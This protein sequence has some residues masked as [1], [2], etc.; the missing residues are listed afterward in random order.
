MTVNDI[1]PKLNNIYFFKYRQEEN[2][3]KK[4]NLLKTQYSYRFMYIASGSLNV[5]I[6]GVTENVNKGDVLYIIPGDFYRLIPLASDFS[7]YSI[8]F[9]IS[10]DK[11]NTDIINGGCVFESEFSSDLCLKKVVFEDAPCLNK[12]GIFRNVFCENIIE[13]IIYADKYNKYYDF[14]VSSHIRSLFAE[15]LV[16]KT[17]GEYEKNTVTDK[18]I[19][20]IRLNYD[21]DISAK[22]IASEFSYHPN[23]IN[24][25]IKKKTG[26][27]ISSFIRHIKIGYALGLF[28]ENQ[29]PLSEI[30]L[31][32][33]YYDYS[34]FYKAFVAETGF[35]PTKYKKTN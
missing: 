20:Y 28:Y 27:N 15:S 30:S 6:N 18:I 34:H 5:S 7:V 32:L 31:M 17:S 14:L 26:K 4:V 35:A 2:K 16:S 9:D 33:G 25:L 22:S 11:R 3:H 13:N 12:S 19:E 10:S 29:I 8:F 1:L 21:K 23:Y 24:K